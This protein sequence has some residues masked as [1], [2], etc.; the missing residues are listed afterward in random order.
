VSIR[1]EVLKTTAGFYVWRIARGDATVHQSHEFLSAK[2]AAASLDQV[3]AAVMWASNNRSVEIHN[4]TGE[5]I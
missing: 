1:F 4:L 3:I 5:E 2:G